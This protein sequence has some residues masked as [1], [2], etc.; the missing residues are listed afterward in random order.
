VDAFHDGKIRFTGIFDII[1]EVVQQ[2]SA[3][4]QLSLDSVLEAETWA[5]Q[6]ADSLIAKH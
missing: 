1:E 4:N 2:H 6:T 5:R 3:S